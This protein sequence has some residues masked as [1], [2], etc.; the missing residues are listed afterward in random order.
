MHQAKINTP[1]CSVD[2]PTALGYV[3]NYA[4][5][6]I[7]NGIFI[8]QTGNFTKHLPP[9]QASPVRSAAKVE[10]ANLNWAHDELAQQQQQQQKWVRK[11]R[12]KFG[13]G[14][15]KKKLRIGK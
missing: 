11:L 13:G 9:T 4:A 3:V 5:Y 7:C 12:R 14:G 15:A 8:K 10:R 2:F 6:L 1:P